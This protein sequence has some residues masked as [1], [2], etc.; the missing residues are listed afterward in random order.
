MKSPLELPLVN[1]RLFLQATRDS[2]YRTTGMAVAEFVDN[3]IQAGAT[4]IEINVAANN[5]EEYPVSISVTDN[6]HGIE[7]SA[8]GAALSFGGSTRFGDR[9]FLGR[10]GMGLPNAALSQARR[11][12]VSTWKGTKNYHC[13]LDLDEIIKEKR[14]G[15]PSIQETVIDCL[16]QSLKSG[17]TVTLSR[18]DRLGFK[19]SS[20]I[21]K[22][23]R[24][25][26]GRIFRSFLLNGLSIL[27][28]GDC[29]E[30][31][32]HLS[33]SKLVK[34]KAYGETLSYEF[35]TQHGVGVVEVRFVE[36]P[37]MTY[38]N[39][40]EAEKRRLGILNAPI[41]SV[42]RAGREI[43]RGWIL[44]GNKRRENY[45]AWW[46]C[47]ISFEP[48]LDELF[49]VTHTKQQV[50]PCVELKQI[51]EP[52]LE[53]IA[54]AMNKRVRQQFEL[55]K[56]ISPL[57][58]AQ[59]TAKRVYPSLSPVKVRKFSRSDVKVAET[60][61]MKVIGLTEPF[62]LLLGELQSTNLYDF[63]FENETLTVLFNLRHPIIRDIFRP[64]A[65]SD[66]PADKQVAKFVALTLLA[67]AR[68]ESQLARSESQLD[69]YR[70]TDDTWSFCKEWSDV[71]AAF[72]NA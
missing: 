48:A 5:E 71:S 16:G 72:L 55:T 15:L 11:L 46:R 36:L 60:E 49:G 13:Y 31:V 17:T 30:P 21:V 34:E 63:T 51:I 27:I 1:E 62:R 37:V 10:F 54:R 33:P 39:F 7:P 45:D 2:G 66:K 38:H 3:S 40:S 61:E 19:R 53:P 69:G 32:G 28:N 25:E 35:S 20:T 41:V 18:C 65:S 4:V 24:G 68:S 67:A 70:A 58:A 29:L 6:G 43:D 59:E 52:D 50:S 56:S 26:L 42:L 14:T 22:K 64:L 47:E 44:M 8:L 9:M 23:L 12:D 57:L